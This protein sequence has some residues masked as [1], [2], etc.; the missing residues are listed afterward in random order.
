MS[1]ALFTI[2]SGYTAASQQ[3]GGYCT[4]TGGTAPLQQ[5]QDVVVTRRGREIN[6]IPAAKIKRIERTTS[7]G[8]HGAKIWFKA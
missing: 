5:G 7:F 1:E 3:Y 2:M 8:K 4:V 6:R